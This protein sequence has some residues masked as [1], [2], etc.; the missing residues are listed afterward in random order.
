M[1]QEEKII[2]VEIV[3]Y[4]IERNKKENY[5]ATFDNL[6]SDVQSVSNKAEKSLIKQ[7]GYLKS[8]GYD[9][10]YQ[11]MIIEKVV[12]YN[13]LCG[14]TYLYDFKN[15]C[16]AF[17]ISIVIFIILLFYIIKSDGDISSTLVTILFYLAAPLLFYSVITMVHSAYE[18]IKYK[19]NKIKSPDPS[20]S[21]E[22]YKVIGVDLKENHNYSKDAVMFYLSN[23][24]FD[25]V[26]LKLLVDELFASKRHVINIMPEKKRFFWQSH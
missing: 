10:E 5:I 6:A 17:I 14:K 24:G 8:L 1:D 11:E 9:Y 13:K 25:Y 19:R 7:R 20:Y 4:L 12:A 2:P 15:G 23:Y 26:G 18:K 22:A 16:V 21:L 3:D